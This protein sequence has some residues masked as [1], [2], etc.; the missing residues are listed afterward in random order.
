MINII[1]N[2]TNNCVFTLFEKT[3]LQNANYILQL[4]SNDDQT[5][6]YMWLYLSANTTGNQQRYDLYEIEE[7]TNED[8]YNL[9]VNLTDS[10][11]DYTVWQTTGST[12]STSALT[13][14]DI[15]ERGALNVTSSG[16]TTPTY[17]NNNTEYTFI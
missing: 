15:V 7:T 6:K 5:D 1:R 14:N 2:T 9:K 4:H 13:I 16:T 11:Y 10:Q 3:T 8:V 12:L 17:N